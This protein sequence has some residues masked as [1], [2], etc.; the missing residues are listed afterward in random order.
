LYVV[1]VVVVVAIVV[2]AVVNVVVIDFVVICCITL[3]FSSAVDVN[4]TQYNSARQLCTFTLPASSDKGGRVTLE[5]SQ[6]VHHIVV[7]PVPS[8][9]SC[10]Y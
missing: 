7:T 3:W 9:V 4:A 6:T 1:V 10:R 8:K 5:T 2:I